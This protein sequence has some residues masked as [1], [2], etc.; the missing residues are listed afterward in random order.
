MGS[1]LS[2]SVWK[3]SLMWQSCREN[4]FQELLNTRIA[5]WIYTVWSLLVIL[6]GQSTFKQ[7]QPWDFF[8]VGDEMLRSADPCKISTHG[9]LSEA[10]TDAV[11]ERNT[12]NYLHSL[13]CCPWDMMCHFF[14]GGLLDYFMLL[15]GIS[16]VS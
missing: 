10:L 2:L 5:I 11:T 9:H 16:K 6:S 3:C 15:Y 4:T 14:N 12:C 1:T 7:L 13:I 8:S